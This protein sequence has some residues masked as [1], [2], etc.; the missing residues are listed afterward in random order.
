MAIKIDDVKNFK[1]KII[2]KGWYAAVIKEIKKGASKKTGAEMG[3][4]TVKII[5]DSPIGGEVTEN[6]LNPLNTHHRLYIVTPDDSVEL[7]KAQYDN[8][9]L[10]TRKF[11]KACGF[12][13]IEDVLNDS[14]NIDWQQ[15]IGQELEI[16]IQHEPMGDYDETVADDD[17]E[18]RASPGYGKFRPI[19]MG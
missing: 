3:T 10:T 6:D 14:N 11:V 1:D 16:L 13:D 9:G 5:D 12:G 19:K 18:Y 7:T 4:V 8:Y 15:F 17:K 2:P